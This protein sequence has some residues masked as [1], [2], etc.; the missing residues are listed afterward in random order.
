MRRLVTTVSL[1]VA[2]T[3]TAIPAHAAPDEDAVRAVLDGMNGSYNRSDFGGF[4]AH[5][6]ADMTVSPAFAAG[7]YRSR[8]ADGPTRITVNSVRVHG[9]EALANVRFVAAEHEKT[10]DI[11]FLREGSRWKACR[12][13]S[14]Q[15][16]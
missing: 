9:D 6:C 2:L 1:V 7:W 12:Y 16:V 3:A 15:A 4:A 13:Q 11:E 14:G 10:L 8:S 5:L